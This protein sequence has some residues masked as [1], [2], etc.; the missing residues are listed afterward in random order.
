MENKIKLLELLF[1]MGFISKQ[2]ID[3]IVQKG[4][5]EASKGYQEEFPAE[6]E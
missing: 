2:E 5:Y 4:L 1:T 6:E 3:A